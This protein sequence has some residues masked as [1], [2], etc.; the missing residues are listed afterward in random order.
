[1]TTAVLEEMTF[2]SSQARPTFYGNLG[3][4]VVSM[5]IRDWTRAKANSIQST[6][7]QCNP[8]KPI[9]ILSFHLCLGLSSWSLHFRISD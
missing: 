7:S 6:P 3:F 5:T 4:T 1:M 2:V 8:L 9:L